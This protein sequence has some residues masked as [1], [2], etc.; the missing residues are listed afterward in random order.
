MRGRTCRQ[1]ARYLTASFPLKHDFRRKGGQIDVDRSEPRHQRTATQHEQAAQ[2]EAR[3]LP[4]LPMPPPARA[5]AHLLRQL[6]LQLRQVLGVAFPVIP[7][8]SGRCGRGGA[9]HLERKEAQAGD[10]L[11]IGALRLLHRPP[12]HPYRT[13]SRRI[14]ESN[15]SL[16]AEKH[17]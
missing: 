3:P 14:S 11:R 1:R 10:E 7:V 6:R 5:D 17:L 15:G 13:K 8:R 2:R 12:L 16:R 4:T 9:L